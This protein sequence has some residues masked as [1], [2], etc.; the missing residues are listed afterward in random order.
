MDYRLTRPDGTIST[1]HTIGEVTYD[2]EGKPLVH[3]GTVQDI[4]E[5]KRTAEALRNSEAM[6][7]AIIDTEPECVKLLDS[8]GRLIDDEP[9]G[10]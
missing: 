6:L 5:R 1:V 10:P 9:C 8:E 4:T 2:P 3:S 7:Q